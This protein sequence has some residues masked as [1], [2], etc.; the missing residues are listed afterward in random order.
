VRESSAFTDEEKALIE[1]ELKNIINKKGEAVIQ[2][3]RRRSQKRNEAEAIAR[4]QELVREALTPEA[5]RI[6][7]KPS[8]ASKRKRV[9]EKRVHS[10]KKRER[11]KKDWD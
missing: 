5:E 2:N 6:P 3:S 4:L 11:G 9:E 7:T 1:A 8:R 10:A